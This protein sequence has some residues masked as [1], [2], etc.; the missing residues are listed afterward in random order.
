MN[1]KTMQKPV[2]DQGA[3]DA[4]RRVPTR[5]K[6]LPRTTLP[7]SHPATSPT[8]KMTDLRSTGFRRRRLCGPEQTSKRAGFQIQCT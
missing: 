8:T 5:P 2:A 4:N 1:P 7:A 3:Y 6:P